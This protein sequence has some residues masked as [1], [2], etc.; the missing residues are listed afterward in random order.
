MV[1]ADHESR[2]G[3]HSIFSVVLIPSS[4]CPRP[5]ATTLSSSRAVHI[6]RTLSRNVSVFSSSAALFDKLSKEHLSSQENLPQETKDKIIH[7]NNNPSMLNRL[8]SYSR[9]SSTKKN[10][11]TI[12]ANENVGFSMPNKINYCSTSRRHISPTMEDEG[13]KSNSAQET[14]CIYAIIQESYI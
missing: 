8:K 11:S 1:C 5:S 12:T 14:V 7:D 2:I 9:V 4:V 10:P 3:A 6:Q 13:N